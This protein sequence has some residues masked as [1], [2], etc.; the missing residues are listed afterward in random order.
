MHKRAN[1]NKIYETAWEALGPHVTNITMRESG[2]PLDPKILRM[3]TVVNKANWG[4]L[5][6]AKLAH[7]YGMPYKTGT[8]THTGPSCPHCGGL[9][10]GGHITG[11]CLHSNMK[12]VYIHRHNKAVQL[13]NKYISKS[14]I[15]NYARYVD[16]YAQEDRPTGVHG[17]GM[18]DW[19]YPE[20]DSRP[21]IVILKGLK[22]N[23]LQK[24]QK[25]L[26]AW[27]RKIEIIVVEVGFCTDTRYKEKLFEKTW[28]HRHMITRMVAKGWHVSQADLVIGNA[29][30]M[31]N[32][33]VE[34]LRHTVHLT[35]DRAHK[36]ASKLSKHA[37]THTHLAIVARRSLDVG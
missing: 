17:R 16:A 21:D 23:Q 13:I 2:P 34:A 22:H 4:I 15:G 11:G 1:P 33:T 9:D 8:G 3:K 5:W 26:E 37:V 18:P 35:P 6:N 10:G 27:K 20:Q 28:Q 36:L 24:M 7:R 25:N 29:G 14:E 31:Y 19:L 32:T 30:T 12:A